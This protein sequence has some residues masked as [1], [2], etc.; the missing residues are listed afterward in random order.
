MWVRLDTKYNLIE[1]EK[2]LHSSCTGP[3]RLFFPM[4]TCYISRRSKT[5]RR[6][7]FRGFEE[8]RIFHSPSGCRDCSWPCTDCLQMP[9]GP[10]KVKGDHHRF[11]KKRVHI[12]Y[13]RWC[14][15]E[16]APAYVN[17]SEPCDVMA[18]LLNF[19]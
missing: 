19:G 7:K 3:W 9:R 4:R 5:H 15:E 10:W 16:P 13:H 18:C 14:Q 8:V 12:P 6:V 17:L 1:I 2:W 11:Y